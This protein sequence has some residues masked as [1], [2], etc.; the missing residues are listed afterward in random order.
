MWIELDNG[1]RIAGFE[2]SSPIC[3]HFFPRI[4]GMPRLNDVLS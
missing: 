1:F 2:S 4:E 3:S